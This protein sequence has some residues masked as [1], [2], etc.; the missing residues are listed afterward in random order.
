[1]ADILSVPDPE[2]PAFLL[3]RSA[4]GDFVRA[5]SSVTPPDMYKAEAII[6]WDTAVPEQ[7]FNALFISQPV[8][9]DAVKIWW[10][11][12]PEG[13]VNWTALCV[14]RSGFGHPST[15]A[16][17]EIV[18]F[19]DRPVPYDTT[20]VPGSFFDKGL[21]SGRWY[22]YTLFFQLSGGKWV[23]V[24]TTHSLVPVDY[25]HRQHLL[26]LVPPFY[27]SWESENSASFITRWMTMIGYDL[28]YTR[29]LAEGVQQIYDPDSAPQVLL[30][31][32]G[33]NNLGFNKPSALGDI[34]YRSV[35]AN[36]R[37]ILFHRGTLSGLETYVEAVFKSE[38]SVS[39]GL[40]ELLLVD[41]AEFLTGVGNW[42]PMPWRIG[43][44]LGISARVGAGANPPTLP[45]NGFQ[46]RHVS[47]T[48]IPEPKTVGVGGV[49]PAPWPLPIEINSARGVARI[50]STVAGEQ[51][52]ITCGAGEQ[53]VIT[54][55]DSSTR[56]LV[57]DEQHL[58]A[59]YR[60]IPVD[61]PDLPTDP[62]IA[63]EPVPVYYFSFW[64]RRDPGNV[65]EQDLIAFGFM[66]YDDKPAT[67]G[68]SD[69]FRGVGG[70]PT[71]PTNPLTTLGGFDSWQA[72]STAV[73]QTTEIVPSPTA[74]LMQRRTIKGGVGTTAD[75]WEHVVGSFPLSRHCRYIVPFIWYQH[76]PGTLGAVPA[77]V[78]TARYITGVLVNASQGVGADQVF[79]LDSYL[80]LLSQTTP[81][82]DLI[83]GVDEDLPAGARDDYKVLE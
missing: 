2:S 57:Y 71:A 51:L 9:Y 68:F 47:I 52:A 61:V 73:P 78:S 7:L 74:L 42:A 3:R 30:D 67:Q 77:P 38:V 76:S 27:L 69:G 83:G 11:A 54:N 34:R 25:Q 66:Q 37:A 58:D 6:R 22:Y 60:G 31:A 72:R 81:T 14:V 35:L 44:E 80:R 29:T 1:M 75:Q 46:T 49:L 40:N 5:G 17:G 16:D 64:S 26:D 19:Q 8:D 33:Q 79:S 36:N 55:V 13:M 53:K 24:A 4:A 15:P 50:Q 23:N 43:H 32:M 70:L 63:P 82:R 65:A 59:F 12:P 45:V 41:D 28:D 10:G 56:T 21:P 20:N 48:S 39:N 62:L 18:H